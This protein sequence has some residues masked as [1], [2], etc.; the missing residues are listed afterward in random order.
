MDILESVKMAVN[1]IK[2]NKV[3]SSLTMLGI[4]IGNGAVIASIGIGMGAKTY[5]NNQIAILGTNILIVRAGGPSGARNPRFLDRPRNLVW[6]DAKAINS[7]VPNIK[8]VAPQ[9]NGSEIVSYRNKNIS[10]LIFGSTPEIGPVRNFTVQKGRFMTNLDVERYAQVA[11]IGSDVATKLFGDNNPIGQKIKIKNVSLEVIGVLESKGS[12]FG[13]NNDETVILPITTMARRLVGRTSPFGLEVTGIF[14]GVNEE[15]KMNAAQFQIENLLRLRHRIVNEDDFTVVSQKDLIQTLNAIS[16]ALSLLL[17]AVAS[18]SLLVGGIGIMNIMLVSVT[19][20]TQEI[21][22]RK[23]IG[24]RPKDILIQFLI[25][26][27][28]LSVAGGFLG[29]SLGIGIVSLVGNFTLLP[30]SV[31]MSGI[32]LAFGISSGIGLFF[33]VIPAS[34]AAKLDPIVALRSI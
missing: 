28:M 4:I 1:T 29:M 8:G 7:Q 22:L 19:E 34:K 23:A 9:L 13:T 33:G 18:I 15:K 12:S 25:E 20:R 16:G 26:S 3:R 14:V 6:D 21:G 17:A 31:P 11:V 32:Y 27:I 24:A 30:A 2:N 10:C 5:V